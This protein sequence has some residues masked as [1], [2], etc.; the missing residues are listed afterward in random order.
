MAEGILNK[1]IL[2]AILLLFL[3]IFAFALY[4]KSGLISKIA[5]LA[6]GAERFLPTEPSK[7]V[8]ADESLPQ[9][10]INTQKT[11]MEEITRHKDNGK[12]L[13]TFSSLSG[14]NDFKMELTNYNGVISRIEKP[15][16]KEGII[17]LNPIQIK[18]EKLQVCVINAESFYECYI[19]PQRICTKQLYNTI[20]SVEISK[21][22][23]IINKNT[24]TLTKD[25]LFKPDKDKVC[26]IPIHSST[27]DSWYKI[28]QVFTKWGC[29]VSKNTI[30]DDCLNIIKSH[31]PE[32][33]KQP[34]SA[35][36]EEVQKAP[37]EEFE[38]F[39][40][41]LNDINS[42][43]HQ[44]ICIKTFNFDT[45]KMKTGFYVYAY[46]DG[47][48]DLKFNN[49]GIGEL[50]ETRNVNYIPIGRLTSKK[51]T[52]NYF[53]NYDS[54]KHTFIVSPLG[55]YTSSDYTTFVSLATSI[56]GVSKDN[57]WILTEPNNYI[58]TIPLC[59]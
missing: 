16:G 38:R 11:F 53:N 4:S 47:R 12:C 41:F 24:Y 13:L 52:E 31:I 29:D 22:D 43:S 37:K 2:W 57:K 28:Y 21:D 26:F 23:I 27:G 17:R 50:I 39:V 33:S 7:E 35:I 25:I 48:I 51:E 49:N 34:K 9:T 15:I 46:T 6:L 8:K 58:N 55:D 42:K 19:G 3:F 18:D 5:N 10:A 59:Q 56:I 45:N 54:F 1:I 30:D 32:C 44:N 40:Q 36:S 14:L 20:N